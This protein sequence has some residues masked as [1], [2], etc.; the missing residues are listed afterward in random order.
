MPVC[1]KYYAWH[2]GDMH[3]KDLMGLNTRV[4]YCIPVPDFYPLLHDLR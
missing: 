2:S 3:L 4:G 1:V